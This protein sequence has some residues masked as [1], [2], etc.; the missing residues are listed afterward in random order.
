MSDADTYEPNMDDFDDDDRP[1]QEEPDYDDEPTDAELYADEYQ[2]QASNAARA[3]DTA[4][5][6]RQ[7]E[8]FTA[9]VAHATL[10]AAA[11]TMYAAARVTQDSVT[12]LAVYS[13]QGQRWVVDGGD[14][15][16]GRYLT[17]HEAMDAAPRYWH[18][19]NPDRPW[20]K[21][22]WTAQDPKSPIHELSMDERQTGITVYPE[23]IGSCWPDSPF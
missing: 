1:I 23:G 9:A 19:L 2:Q 14:V 5:E 20:T 16:A 4:I 7:P 21:P 18:H 6:H 15:I 10:A 12:G 11:A 17:Q 3:I 8:S 13:H 22:A